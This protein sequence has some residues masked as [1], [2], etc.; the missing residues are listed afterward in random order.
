MNF[1]AML[2]GKTTAIVVGA[3]GLL[4]ALLG[5]RHSIRK[6]AKDEMSA[7][8]KER[9]LEQIQRGEKIERDF[10]GMSDDDVITKLRDQGYIRD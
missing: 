5:I 3:V 10:D 4:V 6:G 2:W 9:A 7:E 1:L 8:I